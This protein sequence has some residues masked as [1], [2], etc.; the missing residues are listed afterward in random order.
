MA[1]ATDLAK[2]VRFILRGTTGIM[3]FNNRNMTKPVTL[4]ETLKAQRTACRLHA[5]WI[6][7]VPFVLGTIWGRMRRRCHLM[8]E[9]N[10]D[11]YILATQSVN[12]VFK[13]LVLNSK[14]LF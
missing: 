3:Y 11:S 9:N 4:H 5:I 8:A 10:T 6:H 2:Y 7:S 12:T 13:R 14:T 1:E